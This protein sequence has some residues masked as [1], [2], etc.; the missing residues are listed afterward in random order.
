MAN[1][2]RS[3]LAGIWL[4]AAVS[5]AQVLSN[6]RSLPTSPASSLSSSIWEID[7]RIPNENSGFLPPGT[8][9]HN[10]LPLPF[11]KHV[12]AD[13]KQFWSSPKELRKPDNLKM[14]VPFAGFTG[15]LI[16]SDRWISKQVPDK[17]SQLRASQTLSHYALLSLA[18]AAGSAYVWGHLTHN[19]HLKETGLLS[20]EAALNSSIVSYGFKSFTQRMRPG[21]ARGNAFVQAGNSFP[22]EHSAIAWSVASVVAHEYPGPLTKFLAYGLASAVTI[23]R[24]TSKQHFASDAL[25]GSVLGW[26][27]GRQVY[28]AHHD[29]EVGGAPWG[30]LGSPSYENRSKPRK[31][32]SPYVPL[33]SWIYPAIERLSALGLATSA[34]LNQRPWTRLECAR[35][36]DEIGEH[37]PETDSHDQISRLYKDL[38]LEFAGETAIL[39]R[40]P[41]LNVALDSAYTRVTNISGSPLRDSFHFGQTI[42][43]DYG[44]PYAEGVNIISG[45][46]AY[47]SVGPF[48]FYARGEYQNAGSTSL[49]RSSALQAIAQADGKPLFPNSSAAASRFTLLDSQVALGLGNLQITFGKQSAWL[50]PSRSGSLLLSNNTAPITMLRFDTVS[51]FRIPG[52]SRVLGPMKNEFF[53]GQLSGHT[54]ISDGTSF[55]GPNIDPQPY[56]HGDRISFKPTQNLEVGMGISVMFGGAGLPFTFNNFLRTYY[57]HSPSTSINPGKRFSAFDF[58]YRIPH[59]R[60]WMTVYLDSLVVDEVSPIGS[61]RPSLNPGLYFP[62]IPKV[63]N[64]EFRLEGIKTQQGP[65]IGFPAGY[66]YSDRRYKNGYTNGGDLLLGNWIGRAGVGVQS[67]ATYHFSARNNLEL[68]YRH[69]NVD[70]TFLQGGHISDFGMSTNWMLH[71]GLGL[72]AQLQYEQW[73]FPLLARTAKSNLTASFQLTFWPNASGVARL[74]R[75]NRF[76]GA[77][78]K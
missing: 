21:D 12:A 34:Y 40:G 60:K 57:V 54:S 63:P 32:A 51:P 11:F 56:V 31:L 45:L 22:S 47:A 61:S 7:T 73:G 18:G 48:A 64:L 52:I 58:T 42:V 67:W 36:L 43:N 39:E 2:A 17:L 38:Q 66:V 37:M 69:V 49:Y 74:T 4:L 3:F 16:V 70:H 72:L 8:D 46:S 75:F 6:S 1:V 35:L 53:I 78:Q 9:P 28:R 25:V 14:F 20:G 26:Y 19:D 27:L 62:R 29:L 24:V 50:G 23:T 30:D 71:P 15:M 65:H 41:S 5:H 10:T 68:S 59:L 77:T 76:S 13:Q 33:D 44:R 55:T